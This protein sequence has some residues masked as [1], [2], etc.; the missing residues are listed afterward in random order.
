MIF[1]TPITWLL[2]EVLSLVLFF[3]CIVHATKQKNPQ[4]KVLE[5]FGFCIAAGIFENAG[6]AGKIYDYNTNRIMM[7]GKVPL[8]IILL[9][10]AI[11]Y[12]GLLLV[13]YL[14]VPSWSKPLI[15][16]LF[17]SIQDM[18]LD[19]S[20]VFDLHQ[21]DGVMSGQWNWTFRYDGTFFGIPFFNFS[22]WLYLMAYY[23]AVV[24]LGRWLYN[25]TKN[26]MIGYS[27]PFIAGVTTPLLLSTPLTTLLLFLHPFFPLFTRTPELIML[28]INYSIPMVVL[29]LYRNKMS[30]IDFKKDKII[31]VIPAVLHI[32]D[33]IMG[34]SLGI[35]EAYIP[36]VVVTLIHFSY[37]FYLYRKTKK[38]LSVQER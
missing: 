4:F 38:I 34:Y 25:K 30:A 27:Y 36:S 6:V 8:E 13:G 16:G 3:V 28:I 35:K 10:A 33:I 20:A 2:S 9:E 17:A 14:K 5:L 11:L 32:F 37:L 31:F 24:L 12:V 23:S 1:G 18:T 15:I 7:I 21:L 26:K 29:F 22:G 19:P